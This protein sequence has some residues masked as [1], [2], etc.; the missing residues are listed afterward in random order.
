MALRKLIVEGDPLKTGGIVLPSGATQQLD[1]HPFAYI[2][3]M[4][5]CFVC[6][7][8]GPIIKAGGG[9]RMEVAGGEVEILFGLGSYT[10]DEEVAMEDD[11]V[12]C[13]CPKHP[14]L[15]AVLA[16]TA[17]YDDEMSA[18]AYTGRVLY[19]AGAD[20]VGGAWSLAKG[21]V[22]LA[23]DQAALVV[24]GPLGA[25]GS[26]TA[27]KYYEQAANRNVERVDTA[28]KVP[29]A[30]KDKAVDVWNNPSQITQAENIGHIVGAA[31]P[32]GAATKAGNASKAGAVAESA[33]AAAA[34][35][36]RIRKN[37]FYADGARYDSNMVNGHPIANLRLEYEDAV[38]AGRSEADRQL[39]TGVP[40]E[41]VQYY[42]VDKRNQI[43]TEYR[44]L[45]PP[46]IVKAAENRNQIE[47][48]NPL[49]P[50]VEQLT[51][52]GK[53]PTQIIDGSFRPGGGDMVE[54][55][56]P[57]GFYN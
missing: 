20:L 50:S 53:T 45:T 51:A 9:R 26:T 56:A 8:T 47:Y 15:Q 38:R 27:Q 5:T 4:A 23:A 54:K 3:G 40:P 33:E 34:R 12:V 32:A 19:T 46:E 7:V 11:E 18:L 16:P 43:K 21:T 17:Q 44:S 30:L 28:M 24:Y 31:V 52:K 37:N 39:A 22:S 2:G 57:A 1:G 10:K 29:G 42:A 25:M 49:G 35:A 13:S 36:A 55:F 6:G 14:Q 41:K 48:G